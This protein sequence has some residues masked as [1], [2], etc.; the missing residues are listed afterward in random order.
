M[1]SLYNTVACKS[2]PEGKVKTLNKQLSGTHWRNRSQLEHSWDLWK[3]AEM[4]V[5]DSTNMWENLKSPKLTCWNV[6]FSGNPE[7]LISSW[8][9]KV[10]AS[11]WT[12]PLTSC[13]LLWLILSVHSHW[14]P[15][16]TNGFNVFF[17]TRCSAFMIYFLDK[18]WSSW[19]CCNCKN[20]YFN[21][22]IT[23]HLNV[24]QSYSKQFPNCS[25]LY[26]QNV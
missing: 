7:S 20:K 21:I 18:P 2:I 3:L 17:F 16:S 11:C 15:L 12:F 25:S 22:E 13:S 23:S 9:T 6:R 26:L 8:S 1:L 19:C 4:Y 5:E 14:L 10:V 24:M